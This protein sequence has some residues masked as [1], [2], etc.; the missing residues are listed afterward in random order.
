MNK[1]L[2][3]TTLMTGGLSFATINATQQSSTLPEGPF[4]QEEIDAIE[5]TM[6]LYNSKQLDEA[7]RTQLDGY[8]KEKSYDIHSF[9]KR[10]ISIGKVNEC[11]RSAEQQFDIEFD[12][13]KNKDGD[14]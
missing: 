14:Q 7:T 3:L 13:E 9:F 1:S 4:F 5:G 8:L 12:G 2:F 6:R 11:T 10:L